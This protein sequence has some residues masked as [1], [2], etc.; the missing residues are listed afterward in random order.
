MVFPLFLETPIYR[1]KQKRHFHRQTW[2]EANHV[3]VE[4]FD[5][6][7]WVIFFKI[8]Y[9]HPYLCI[10]PGGD[11]WVNISTYLSLP[12]RIAGRRPHWSIDTPIPI[13]RHMAASAQSPPRTAAWWAN[14]N[15][16]TRK[17]TSIYREWRG[18]GRIFEMPYIMKNKCHIKWKQDHLLTS[19]FHGF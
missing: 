4:N 2:I 18:D 15:M 12:W 14:G 17:M 13:S 11:F 6:Y 3:A 1:N 19:M 5:L 16:T 8:P 9:F 7:R 10:Y